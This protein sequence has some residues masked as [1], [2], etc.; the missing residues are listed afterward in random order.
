MYDKILAAIDHSEIS[1]RALAAARDLALLSGMPPGW[2][3][4]GCR[5]GRAATGLGARLPRRHLGPR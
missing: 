2:S 5:P 3:C 4:T 1:D